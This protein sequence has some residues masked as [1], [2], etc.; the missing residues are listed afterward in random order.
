MKQ[1]NKQILLTISIMISNRPDTVRRCLDSVKPLLEQLPAELILTD[2][3]CGDEVRAVI[4]EYTDRII[5]FEWCRD[6]SAARNAGLKRAKGKWFLY[7]DD[8]E[9]FEDVSSIVRF[10]KS[11]EY[12]AYGFGLYA[13]RNYLDFEGAEYADL[14][15]SRMIR[16]EPDIRFIYRIHESF[17]RAPGLP[18]KLDAY[19]HHYGYVY[20]DEGERRAHAMRNISLLKEELEAEPRNLRHAMQLAQEY[21]SIGERESS[22]EVSLDSIARAEAEPVENGYCVA[23][24]CANEI[25]CYIELGRYEDAARRGERHLRNGSADCLAKA[26][27]A[28]RLTTVYLEKEEYDKCLERA[29]AYWDAYQEY[30]QNDEKFAEFET[31]VTNTCFHERR[32]AVILGNGVRAAIRLGEDALAWQWFRRIGWEGAKPCADAQ[33]IIDILERMLSAKEP[34]RGYAREMCGILLEQEEWRG[35][36]LQ[37]MMDSCRRGRTFEDRIQAAA[38]YRNVAGEHWFLKLAGLSVAAFWG[39][40][41]SRSAAGNGDAGRKE[42]QDAAGERCEQETVGECCEQGAAGERCEQETVGEHCEQDA[43][44]TEAGGPADAAAAESYTPEEAERI[45]AEIWEV[46]EESMPMMEALDLPGAVRHFGGDNGR[47]LERIPFSRW[48]RGTE[49]YFSRYAWR[50]AAWWQER[51]GDIS[52]ADSLRMLVWRAGCGISRASGEAAAMEKAGSQETEEDDSDRVRGTIDG[53]LE[54]LG[55]YAVCRTAL[56]ERIYRQEIIRDMPEILPEEYRGAY[57]I[58]NLLEMTE[59]QQYN[60]AVNAVRE[61]KELLPGLAGIMK[62][63]LLWLNAQM[64]RQREESR[65]AAG[66]F[67]VLARQIKGKVHGLIA[68]GEYRTA[69]AVTGQ[70]LALLP[71]DQEILRLQEE[72]GRKIQGN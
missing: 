55:E 66:E 16:L 23:S 69:L 49:W 64:E 54:G 2:T 44:R 36:V 39:N 25:N 4:E 32:L 31:P 41:K 27:I 70:L 61:I 43:D 45:A 13:Q 50:D 3:G 63:Y 17:N 1:M 15:V 48:E 51:F 10:F 20:R 62:H 59:K 40:G 18:K 67:Q 71:G 5:D 68:A 21:N 14:L 47:V 57:A 28:G 30:R 35:F 29:Q 65:Q 46:M 12:Q 42:R 11:G 24:L 9:W 7:L 19:V 34:E 72:I 60:Q 26:L 37:T 56:C 33:M 22:L 52:E 58:G 38:A 6:F 8:D 53:I